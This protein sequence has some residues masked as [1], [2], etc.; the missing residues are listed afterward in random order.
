VHDAP[1]FHVGRKKIGKN[2]ARRCL[3]RRLSAP[4]SVAIARI[5]PM[6]LKTPVDRRPREAATVPISGA[7][8]C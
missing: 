8:R 2:V 4:Q 6:V 7:D 3:R 5:A 1:H